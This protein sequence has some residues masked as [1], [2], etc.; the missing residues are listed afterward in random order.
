MAK[1]LVF[2][3][4][5]C[6]CLGIQNGL[7][8]TPPMGWNS[9]NHFACSITEDTIKL[10]ADQL[11]STGLRDA[12]YVYVN[13]DDC[14][15]ELTRDTDGKI[16]PHLN[17]FP[18]GIKHL[19]DYV[20]GLGLKLGIYSDAGIKTCGGQP[21]SLNYEDIDA[22]TFASWEIDYIKYD[23]C[24]NE[25]VP[26]KQRYTAMR[27]ALDKVD[28]PI[29]YSICN[30]G[31]EDTTSWAPQLAN[32]WRT[33]ADIVS[34][35]VS[36]QYNFRLNARHPEVAGPG[37]WNDPDMLEVGN[38]G[39]SRALAKTHFTLW[40]FV[41]SPLLLGND[42]GNIAQ[43]DMEIISNK[44]IIAINQDPLGKQAT[45]RL[46]C[47]WPNIILGYNP[48]IWATELENGDVAFA[49]VNWNSYTYTWQT[50]EFE[51]HLGLNSEDTYLVR[52]LWEHKDLGE[53]NKFFISDWI[54][55]EGV[56]AYRVSKKL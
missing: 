44:E 24:F 20:H 49:F 5:V 2:I 56:S 8:L 6:G 42:L 16:V 1:R 39:I 13:I 12:G 11:V 48:E 52:D 22:A 32:S 7:G 30:W 19:A 36:I 38:T 21:G 47:S 53:F 54:E 27:K 23:N 41:K 10:A 51:K 18:N 14:W 55:P 34:S 46:G 50:V 15:A 33:T 4:L 35:M 45:C 37:G 25:D 3:L 40:A 43:E 26:A 9:W 31:Y 28:R 29:F 17:N